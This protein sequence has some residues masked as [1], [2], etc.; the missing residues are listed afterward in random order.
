M[1]KKLLLIGT[2]DINQ[3]R[4]QVIL[5]GLKEL[6]FDHKIINHDIWGKAKKYNLNLKE[7]LL[8]LIKYFKFY[9]TNFWKIIN[10]IKNHDVILIPY[11][12]YFDLIILSPICYLFKKKLYLDLFISLYN[13]SVE[14]RKIIKYIFAKKIIFYFEK[15]ILNLASKIIIDTNLHKNYLTKT[16]NLNKKK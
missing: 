15:F 14:D 11:P 13:T 8:I 4:L 2:F 3:N 10:E 16:Y 6:K 7:V 5:S 9:I 1:K 12:G